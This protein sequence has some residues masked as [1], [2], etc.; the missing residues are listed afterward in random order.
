M[1][2]AELISLSLMEAIRLVRERELS[3]VELTQAYLERIEALE[4]HLNSFITVTADLALHQA[5]QAEAELV[6]GETHDGHPLGSLHGAPIAL[7]DLFETASVRTTAG[8]LFFKDF[9]PAEDASAYQKLRKAGAILLGKTNLHEIALGLTC[10][11]PH[12]GTVRNPWMKD[13]MTGGSSGGSAAALVARLCPGSLGTD[14]G[15]SIRVPAA[16]CGVAGLK[17][18]SRPGKPARG[19]PAELESGSCWSDGTRR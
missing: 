17:P 16:L 4:P 13:R 19:D 6:R 3:P 1:S 11:N 9:I 15:G 14:T 8:S 18:N 7:K 12:Y 2:A 5:R 10:V